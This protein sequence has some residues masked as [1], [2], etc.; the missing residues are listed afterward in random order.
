M[1]DS[2][3]TA[4]LIAERLAAFLSAQTGKS[5]TIRE[6]SRFPVGFSWITYG[7]TLD[8]PGEQSRDLIL[9]LAPPAGLLPPYSAAPEYSVLSAIRGI[10]VPAPEAL[11]FSD[12]PSAMGA[13]FFIC[14]RMVGAPPMFDRK[15]MIENKG[16][17]LTLADQF[18]DILARLHAFDWQNS[19]FG[20]LS[21]PV[22]AE[23]TGHTQLDHW[24]TFI[25]GV[26]LHPHPLLDWTTRWL[27]ANAPVA[28][29]VSIVHGDYRLGNFLA[30]N[31][32]ITAILDWEMVHL[33]D[34]Q[35]DIGWALIPDFNGRSDKLFG[36]VDR[37]AFLERYEQASGIT[38]NAAAVRYYEIFALYKLAAIGLSGTHAFLIG[39]SDD[40]RM[41]MLGSTGVAI[42][43]QLANLA[44]AA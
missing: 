35:E 27:R 33:G 21:A 43:K 16:S 11:W 13:P 34:P 3:T 39:G 36:V 5:A 24:E 7:F 8:L 41:W 31:D 14:T 4:A 12:N 23:R 44:E 19:S 26:L 10:D 2:Y 18:T 42:M 40:L 15:A 29:C 38:V 37:S 6:M 20:T 30:E 1:S 22:T 25:N 9:R 17:L 32:R 28:P